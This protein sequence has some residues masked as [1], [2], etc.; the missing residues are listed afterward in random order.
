VSGPASDARTHRRYLTLLAVLA[1]HA[2]LILA[3]AK[4]R[5]SHVAISTTSPMEL[6]YLP[7]QAASRVRPN[8]PS[9]NSLDREAKTAIAAPSAI[10]IPPSAAPAGSS[11][12]PIDW[13][14]E[15][16]AAAQAMTAPNPEARSFDHRMPEAQQP[17]QSIF[18]DRS[19]HRAGEQFKTEDGR[20]VRYV[21]DDCYQVS[22]PF[23]SPNA[24][25]TGMGMQ[26]YCRRKSKTPRGDLFE[27]LPAYEQLHRSR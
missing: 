9:P 11:G 24:L 15:V 25:S 16:H 1:F 27:Q 19:A 17:S 10:T 18:D 23:A 21:N 12:A 8:W 13:E 7:P 20:W 26:T 14:N 5:T 22:D 6:L 4:S 2:A 3:M